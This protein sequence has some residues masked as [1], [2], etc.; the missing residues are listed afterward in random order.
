MDNGT[1]QVGRLQ[2]EPKERIFNTGLKCAGVGE[3][4]IESKSKNHW[5]RDSIFSRYAG[6]LLLLEMAL[7]ALMKESK[8]HPT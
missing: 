5:Q 7:V 4:R 6:V 8:G 3:G 2:Y 1:S